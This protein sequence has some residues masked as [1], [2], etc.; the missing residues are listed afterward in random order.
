MRDSSNIHLRKKLN[1]AGAG[2]RSSATDKPKLSSIAASR[3]TYSASVATFGHLLAMNLREAE[4]VRIVLRRQADHL[5]AK[6]SDLLPAQAF[7][8]IVAVYNSKLFAD[9][10]GLFQLLVVLEENGIRFADREDSIAL[11]AG[12]SQRI[13]KEVP[14]HH[15]ISAQSMTAQTRFEYV[16]PQAELLF[17]IFQQAGRH[18][19]AA[20]YIGEE[21]PYSADMYLCAF[22][23]LATSGIMLSACRLLRLAWQAQLHNIPMDTLV[24]WI[25]QHWGRRLDDLVGLMFDGLVNEETFWAL[26]QY[27]QLVQTLGYEELRE[28]LVRYH[29]R[30]ESDD[31]LNLA[32]AIREQLYPH[33][34]PGATQPVT[35]VELLKSGTLLSVLERFAETRKIPG[36]FDFYL[37]ERCFST[38]TDRPTFTSILLGDFEPLAEIEIPEPAHEHVGVSAGTLTVEDMLILIGDELRG[39][40]GTTAFVSGPARHV[41][42]TLGSLDQVFDAIR[43]GNPDALLDVWV[44]WSTLMRA[45]LD[46]LH[47]FDPKDLGPREAGASVWTPAAEIP[48]TTGI[49]SESVAPPVEEPPPAPPEPKP[50]TETVPTPTPQPIALVTPIVVEPEPPSVS[51]PE[52]ETKPPNLYP[53]IPEPYRERL[54]LADGQIKQ[55]KGNIMRKGLREEHNA[56]LA[57]TRDLP[58]SRTKL[59][60]ALAILET[61]LAETLKFVSM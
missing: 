32:R 35:E 12:V 33:G 24:L 17:S 8:Q 41:A 58:S 61:N 36:R 6:T 48:E 59:M 13:L 39:Q 29:A 44:A 60:V 30:Y 19:P 43:S 21:T 28:L 5:A 56:C 50:A 52:P 23:L 16:F 54:I 40:F 45:A 9:T 2:G 11:L 3:L 55:V 49:A 53:E 34:M 31:L 20:K 42:R 26:T 51:T 14:A 7:D 27:P 38:G 57:L 10:N 1:G 4:L 37:A 46:R 47:A 18:P 22:D 25:R 15:R